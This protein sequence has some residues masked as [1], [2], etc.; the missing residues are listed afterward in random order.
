MCVAGC[1]TSEPG[2]AHTTAPV[3]VT[4][5]PTPTETLLPGS[6]SPNSAVGQVVDGFP[7]ALLPVPA[8]AEV[9]V[10]S[11]VPVDGTDLTQVSLNLRTE[12]ATAELLAAISAP[13][14]AA[15]FQAGTP[16]VAE[17]GLAAQATFS[18]DNGNELLVAG[19]LDRD[20]ERTLTLGGRVRTAAP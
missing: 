15:G 17:P 11:A 14:V 13:L 16:S 7:T 10:S 8:G 2:T 3:A 12:Q 9:L 6:D 5:S 4:S 18:R 19:I 20:G 1:T